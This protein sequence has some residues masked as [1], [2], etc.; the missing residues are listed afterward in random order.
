[1]WEQSFDKHADFLK[2]SCFCKISS[3]NVVVL[4]TLASCCVVQNDTKYLSQDPNYVD[5]TADHKHGSCFGIRRHLQANIVLL[6]YFSCSSRN[7]PEFGLL[8]QNT[9]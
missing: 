5:I 9:F 6:S 1:V 3:S 4:H 2:G 7:V 8:V